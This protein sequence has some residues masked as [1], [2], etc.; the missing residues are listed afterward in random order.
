MGG[1]NSNLRKEYLVFPVDRVVNYEG[2]DGYRALETS[3][4]FP[5]IAFSFFSIFFSLFL[6]CEICRS[7]PAFRSELTQ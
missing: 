3:F 2:E 6:F 1:K 5:A 7:L 4:C